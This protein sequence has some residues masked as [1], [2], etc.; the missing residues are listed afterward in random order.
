MIEWT[1]LCTERLNKNFMS[2][3]KFYRRYNFNTEL[4]AML[5]NDRERFTILMR[6]GLYAEHHCSA[7]E[8]QES[9]GRMQTH[10]EITKQFKDAGLA[11]DGIMRERV[12]QIE[13]K[14]L[15]KLRAPKMFSKKQAEEWT[16]WTPK[17][18]SAI[19]AISDYADTTRFD[20]LQ[21]DR[22]KDLM[23]YMGQPER[24]VEERLAHI[25]SQPGHSPDDFTCSGMMDDEIFYEL[26]ASG[27][28]HQRVRELSGFKCA[29]CE[30]A[31]MHAVE[32]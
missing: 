20:Q 11:P 14:A 15:R 17:L 26:D 21:R 8:R 7:C 29:L 25:A 31:E 10:D 27:V 16:E 13:A 19:G 4:A 1:D 9:S 18:M 5:P 2:Y 32:V 12:R 22:S 3:N 24:T 30:Y 23:E 28:L 6:F